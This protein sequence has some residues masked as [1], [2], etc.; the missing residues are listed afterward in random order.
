MLTR[1][2]LWLFALAVP[3]AG[4]ASV[5]LDVEPSV[6]LVFWRGEK[7]FLAAGGAPHV[8]MVQL[9]FGPPLEG[10][11]D[12]S[13]SGQPVGAVS[14]ASASGQRL[15]LLARRHYTEEWAAYVVDAASG[16]VEAA[17]PHQGR[18]VALAPGGRRVAL[19]PPSPK[20]IFGLDVVVWDLETSASRVLVPGPSPVDARVRLS[21]HPSGEALAY[22]GADGWIYSVELAGGPPTRLVEGTAPA[23]APDGR[24]LAFRRGQTVH[25]YEP[26]TGRVTALHTRRA[27]QSGL[28][29]GLPSWSPD[30]KY[31]TWNG[32]IFYDIE[33]ILIEAATGRARSIS[34]GPYW[35]GPWLEFSRLH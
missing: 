18:G 6:R 19:A 33:C 24:R 20:P 35:C 2:S 15:A 27:W 9:A 12:K 8:D 28:N 22:D 1:L 5:R 10:M 3:V 4:C 23:W 11:A 31:L 7:V 13:P 14:D 26:A 32:E 16:R 29:A 21:W 30:G 34:R 17:V 25:L